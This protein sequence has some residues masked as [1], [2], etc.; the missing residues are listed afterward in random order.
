MRLTEG[1]YRPTIQSWLAVGTHTS[2]QP[3]ITK[4]VTSDF[5]IQ[6][7]VADVRDSSWV[8]VGKPLCRIPEPTTL[9]IFSLSHRYGIFTAGNC[10]GFGFHQERTIQEQLITMIGTKRDGRIL[11]NTRIFQASY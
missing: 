11:T 2:N 1:Q 9:S 10:T 3:S 8:G 7:K 5:P 4:D 6:D